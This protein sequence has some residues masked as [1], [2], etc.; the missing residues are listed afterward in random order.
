MLD[1]LIVLSE[2]LF[3]TLYALTWLL[4]LRAPQRS[5][6]L[7]LVA[8]GCAMTRYAGV[9]VVE[10]PAKGALAGASQERTARSVRRCR[11]A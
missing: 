4:M 1:H 11:C 10:S 2:P 5:W 9:S 3:P 7:G 6:A 8:A